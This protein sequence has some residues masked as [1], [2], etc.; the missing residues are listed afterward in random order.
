RVAGRSRCESDLAP[1][2]AWVDS[3]NLQQ[4]R[5]EPLGLRA[6]YDSV[7]SG[8]TPVSGSQ[9]GLQSDSVGQSARTGK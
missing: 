7:H 5:I 1:L 2:L 9:L 8:N 4:I 6:V 3:L